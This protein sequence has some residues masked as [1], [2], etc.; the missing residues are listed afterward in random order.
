MSDGSL[1]AEDLVGHAP[2]PIGTYEAGDGSLPYY[3][4]MALGCLALGCAVVANIDVFRADIAFI[5]VHFYEFLCMFD[6]PGFLVN[7]TATM[8]LLPGLEL[9]VMNKWNFI[10]DPA[11][12]IRRLTHLASYTLNLEGYGFIQ[13]NALSP[14]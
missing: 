13:F 1:P 8:T 2:H 14:G 3:I 7:R 5:D 11:D 6:F 9:D 10:H 4:L 12:G